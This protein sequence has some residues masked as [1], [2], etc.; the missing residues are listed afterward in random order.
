MIGQSTAVHFQRQPAKGTIYHQP[1]IQPANEEPHDCEAG[2]YSV[3]LIVSSNI[4][5]RSIHSSHFVCKVRQVSKAHLSLD[6]TALSC[7]SKMRGSGTASKMA[8]KNNEGV[9]PD[10]PNFWKTASCAMYGVK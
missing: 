8:P 6:S 2:Y 5:T 9:I 4:E 1:L 10:L 7:L 3:G